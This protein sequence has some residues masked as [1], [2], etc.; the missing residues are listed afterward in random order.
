[1]MYNLSYLLVFDKLL[2]TVPRNLAL[3][4][5]QEIHNLHS[6]SL[7]QHKEQHVHNYIHVHQ[8]YMLCIG[9]HVGQDLYYTHIYGIYNIYN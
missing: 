3:P 9:F 4:V 1:M 6:W 2:V 5:T 8:E 7:K